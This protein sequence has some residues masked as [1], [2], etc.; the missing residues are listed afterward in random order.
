MFWLDALNIPSHR[1][2]ADKSS[3]PKGSEVREI[4]YLGV[5]VLWWPGEAGG[6]HMSKEE[7]EPY[8]LL[9]DRELDAILN[10]F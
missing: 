7:L 8:R 2:S 4:Q 9:G 5:K 10:F 6:F 1:F 3:W